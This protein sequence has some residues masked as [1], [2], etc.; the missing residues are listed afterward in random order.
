[1]GRPI[2]LTDNQP[3]PA[4]WVNNVQYGP[5]G[6]LKQISY[7]LAY[8]YG[9]G[10][11]LYYGGSNTETRQYNSRTQLTRLTAPGMD[12]EYR[13]SATQNNG[14]ITQQSDGQEV[15]YTYDSLNRLIAAVTTGPEWGQSFTY[16]GFGNRTGATVT[17]RRAQKLATPLSR[18]LGNIGA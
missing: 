9:D 18:Q 5:A 17:L 10:A 15:T 7:G 14:Q 2:Q 13:Y 8:G 11:R 3:S 1:M 6:E 16:D 4:T 12:I